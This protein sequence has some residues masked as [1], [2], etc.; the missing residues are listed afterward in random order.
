[1]GAGIEVKFNG[2]V[3]LAPSVHSSGA[4]YRWIND[5]FHLPVV[6]WP[7][8]LIPASELPKPQRPSAQPANSAPRA[9]GLDRVRMKCEEISRVDYGNSATEVWK[10]STHVGQYVAEKQVSEEAAWELLS[11]ALD[12]WTY[13]SYADEKNMIQQLENGFRVGLGQ[14]R[15]EWVQQ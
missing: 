10:L 1:L 3:L 4:H 7:K 13:T 8:Q 14:P 5:L 2:Y 6:P 11:H 15:D 9:G 12:G